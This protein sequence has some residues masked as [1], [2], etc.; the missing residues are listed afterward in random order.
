V[1]TTTVRYYERRGMLHPDSRSPS[2]YRQYGP[3]ALERLCFI[4]AAQASGFSLDDVA[5]LLELRE[6]ATVGSTC[7]AQVAGLI[8]NRL[9]EIQRRMNE[10]ARVHV[11]LEASLRTCQ[12]AGGAGC[13][14]LE[15]LTRS[16]KLGK[17]LE[18]R[19]SP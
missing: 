8:S 6:E 7:R 13:G 15:R 2:R 14:V 16:A 11:A 10:L 5:A 12:Q 1:P 3:A 9:D 18:R 4:K 17:S 19:N